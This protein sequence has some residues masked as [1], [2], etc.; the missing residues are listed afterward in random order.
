MIK[1]YGIIA[2]TSVTMLKTRSLVK[3]K[4]LR[5]SLTRDLKR[6]ILVILY[7]KSIT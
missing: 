5:V 1:N 7:V 6:K 4:A 3:S 2:S